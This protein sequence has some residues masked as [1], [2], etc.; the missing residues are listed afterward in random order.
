MSPQS[1]HSEHNKSGDEPHHVRGQRIAARTN[2]G[3]TKERKANQNRIRGVIQRIRSKRAKGASE[4]AKEN[5]KR[6]KEAVDA[7]RGGARRGQEPKCSVVRS[8]AYVEPHTRCGQKK[9]GA[10]KEE[11]PRV[12]E[13]KEQSR[14]TH[15]REL[16]AHWHMYHP[17]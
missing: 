6:I 2:H 12:R 10:S 13:M 3:S 5:P 11:R 7:T 17:T 14:T 4:N 1:I 15:A 16:V 9:A 8:W